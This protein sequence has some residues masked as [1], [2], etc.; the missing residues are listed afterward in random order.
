MKECKRRVPSS[1]VLAFSTS[2]CRQTSTSV[3]EGTVRRGGRCVKNVFLRPL[4]SHCG[5]AGVFVC[6][7]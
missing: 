1:T 5:S 3:S 7:G 2:V 6:S 4:L